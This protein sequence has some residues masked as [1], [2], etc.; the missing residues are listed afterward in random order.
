MTAYTEA[1]RVLFMEIKLGVAKATV[2]KIKVA[3]KLAER[4]GITFGAALRLITRAEEA[5]KK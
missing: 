2:T 3:E 1:Y 4:K 5:A